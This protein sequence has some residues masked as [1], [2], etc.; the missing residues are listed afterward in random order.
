M[1]KRVLTIAAVLASALAWSAAA[2]DS[3]GAPPAELERA[4]RSPP[5]S[6]KPWVYWF[7]LNGNITKEGIT[8]DLEAMRRVGVGGVLIMEVDQGAPVG[9][10]DFMGPKWGELFKHVAVEAQR[11]EIEV[12]M[13]N[14]AGW[15][16]S[17]GPWI[18]PELSMQKVV[19]SE[20]AV[21]GPGRFEG[22]LPQPQAMAGFFRDIV[23][24][25]FPA[26]GAYRIENLPGKAAYTVAQVGPPAA[27]DLPA[28]MVIDRAKIVDLTAKM[29]KGGRLAWDAPPGKWTVL[30]I[31][32]TST[33]VQN[34]P[35]PATGR[36]LECDKLSKEG[37]AANFDGMMRKLIADAGPGGGP[38][39]EG[40]GPLGQHPGTAGLEQFQ[41]RG[42]DPPGLALQE[43]HCDLDPGG[44]QF[45]E[46]LAGNLGESVV[47]GHHDAADPGRNDGLGTRGRLAV[48]AAR[49]QRDQHGRP[50]GPGTGQLQR[51]DLRMG[52]AEA[53]VPPF[54][55]DLRPLDDDA[56]DH[57]VGLDVPLPE[58]GQLQ[59]P[60][61]V[62]K[63]EFGLVHGAEGIRD[64][65]LGPDST[66]SARRHGWAS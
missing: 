23:V 12:N 54:A 1:F 55:D 13:N 5:H 20:T 48:V 63:V 24:L 42:I 57:R 35:A 61:H 3:R 14:D 32:H 29:D 4:F 2:S 39:V 9:P 33:G 41:V 47:P 38:A 66:F 19:F 22:P 21:E 10:I 25:A 43:A 65:G 51:L 6:A 28:E 16:G 11:L 31:G 52:L 62:P 58:D 50:G 17:G 34:A 60:P 18:K 59:R 27:K 53:A 15:N 7:W 36:G 40:H 44:R 8:A 30:R 64:W 46:P 26:P 45:A 37:V 49:L 56:S